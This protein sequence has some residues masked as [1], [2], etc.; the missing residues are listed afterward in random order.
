VLI[1]IKHALSGK[2]VAA[3]H[4]VICSELASL[5]NKGTLHME[6]PALGRNAIGKNWVFKVKTIPDGS[7]NR[8]KARLI[9]QGFNQ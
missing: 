5:H 3:W 1:D 7:V 2:Y 4:K 9:A 6:N 8:F